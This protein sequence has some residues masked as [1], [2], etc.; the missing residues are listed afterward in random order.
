MIPEVVVFVRAMVPEP[1]GLD[2]VEFGAMNVNGSMREYFTGA[3][4]YLG[5]DSRPGPG[6]D[7]VCWSWDTPETKPVDLVLY[8]ETFEHDPKPWRTLERA[9]QI[10]KSGGRVIVT[11]S[12]YGYPKHDHPVDLW[13]VSAEGMVSILEGAGFKVDTCID[14]TQVSEIH[15]V[16]KKE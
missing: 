15:A 6:V 7:T 1:A 8:L 5:V 14:A 2:V 3:A 16:G 10:L 12:G 13:R 9:F 11:A 4:S